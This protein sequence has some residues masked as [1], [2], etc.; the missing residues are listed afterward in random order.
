MRVWCHVALEERT[1]S[2]W[3]AKCHALV[4]HGK[5]VVD[6]WAWVTLGM[7]EMLGVKMV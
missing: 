3:E 2:T 4:M 7:E 5:I 6:K 1:L